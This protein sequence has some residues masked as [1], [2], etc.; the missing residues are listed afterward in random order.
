MKYINYTFILIVITHFGELLAAESGLK[1]ISTQELQMCQMM[2]SDGIRY[3]QSEVKLRNS[4]CFNYVTQ[5]DS[6]LD[7]QLGVS[8]GM[9]PE[10]L[11]QRCFLAGFREGT[12]AQISESFE[13]CADQFQNSV[14]AFMRL[15]YAACY[16]QN[17]SNG[18]VIVSDI[19]VVNSEEFRK[20]SVLMRDPID[21]HWYQTLI[22]NG[23]VGLKTGCVLGEADSILNKKFLYSTDNQSG[24]IEVI[25]AESVGKIFAKSFCG[26]SEPSIIELKN[27]IPAQMISKFSVQF[28]KSWNEN[29]HEKI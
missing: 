17:S 19:S 23:A 29:C 12:A 1:I 7:E 18:Q 10:A 4:T 8:K 11:P 2:R 5:F 20:H 27:F 3:S 28:A 14:N 6:I 9:N 26:A 22:D 24:D 15:G 25:A 13:K 16:L 21:P